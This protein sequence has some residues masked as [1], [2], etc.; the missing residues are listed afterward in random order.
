MRISAP[1]E[2]LFHSTR[3]CSRFPANRQ[4]NRERETET[5]SAVS[6]LPPWR[7]T[8]RHAFFKAV[9]SVT[10]FE[11]KASGSFRKLRAAKKPVS[12]SAQLSMPTAA[13]G[14]CRAGPP[15]SASPAPGFRWRT[16]RCTPGCGRSGRQCRKPARKVTG[17]RMAQQGP[18]GGAGMATS[19]RPAAEAAARRLPEP[20]EICGGLP[21]PLRA[22]C[23]KTKRR[24]RRER[25]PDRKEQNAGH[26]HTASTPRATSA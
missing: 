20:R 19:I 1:S 9:M 21:L 24:A 4:R 7:R 11:S 18:S 3:F 8:L 17:N 23:R 26:Q 10:S 15:S 6:V 12:S 5:A 16:G 25:L 13:P 22:T 2:S 14:Y